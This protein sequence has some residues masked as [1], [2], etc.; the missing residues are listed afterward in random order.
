MLKLM[1]IK[2]KNSR[3]MIDITLNLDVADIRW[4][5]QIADISELSEKV[6]EQAFSFAFQNDD[7][8]KNLLNNAK[9]SVN[10]RLSDDAEVWLL[11]RDFR[12]MDKPTNV[13][14]FA[15]IDYCDFATVPAGETAEL[16]DIIIAFETMQKE[17]IGENITLKAHYCHLLVHG[18]LHILG[19]DH[20]E[21]DEAEYMESFETAILANLGIDN[22]YKDEN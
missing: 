5:E 20:I 6:K 10:V 8:V 21:D 4:Q 14:S 12:N 2:A 18:F 16:G 22:P 3:K 1:R 9:F 11:N 19:F 15:N 17:A 13:L 7:D